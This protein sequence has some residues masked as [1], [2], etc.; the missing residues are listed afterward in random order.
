MYIAFRARVCVWIEICMHHVNE[1]IY[2]IFY[3][4]N[5]MKP[6][7]QLRF[8]K[9][10][11]ALQRKIHNWRNAYTQKEREREWDKERVTDTTI[12]GLLW[13]SLCVLDRTV[14]PHS[15]ICIHFIHKC[16]AYYY[17]YFAS[18]L[19]QSQLIYIYGYIYKCVYVWI[20]LILS[21]QMCK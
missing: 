3:Y 14:K 7:F 5:W 16:T 2:T 17:Y 20:L 6:V 10:A 4:A 18:L 9:C 19:S 11:F 8:G 12:H 13:Y 21:M 1:R 15:I